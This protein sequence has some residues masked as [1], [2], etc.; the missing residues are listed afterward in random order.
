MNELIPATGQ[1]KDFWLLSSTKTYT[2]KTQLIDKTL[3]S[4]KDEILFLYK[5]LEP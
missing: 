2:L 4:P 3:Q 5:T 1:T